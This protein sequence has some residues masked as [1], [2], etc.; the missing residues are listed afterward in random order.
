[1]GDKAQRIGEGEM[2]EGF[3]TDTVQ[4]LMD[5]FALGTGLEPI[6]E[7]PR[8]YLWTDAFAVCNFLELYARTGNEAYMALALRLIDQVHEV[9]G[10][11]RQ[12]D[13]RSGWISGLDEQEG[14]LHPTQ[15][16]LR[17][18]KKLRERRPKE[19]F[20]EDLEWDRDGQYFHYSTRWMHALH[21]ASVVTGD[22]HFNEWAIELA[23]T[24]HARFTYAPPSGEKKSMYWKMSIDLSYPLV[25]SMGHHDP[26][27]G[28][29]T[30]HELQKGRAENGSGSHGLN[31]DAEIADMSAICERIKWATGDP[32]GLGGLL[33]DAF[34]VAQLIIAKELNT[35]DLLETLLTDSLLG[36][37]YYAQNNTLNLPAEYRLAFRELGL[38]IGLRALERLEELVDQKL[39][40]FKRRHQLQYAIHALTQYKPLCDVIERFWVEPRTQTSETW[41]EHLDINMVMLATSLAPV[42]YLSL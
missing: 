9:L 24:S 41:K 33:V 7:T 30:Y 1:M 6:L 38:S 2:K 17:I 21:C 40:V 25:P 18:G 34:R 28:W 15:G 32:L 20:Q 26:L 35:E 36:L 14:K 5:E 19:P 16:G 8:R 31:L 3:Y 11:H 10:K 23:K 13:A 39:N 37:K 4:K 22:D 27:D 42:G 29:I 12:D